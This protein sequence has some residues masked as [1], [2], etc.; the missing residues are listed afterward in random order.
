M[1]QIF[2][3]LCAAATFLAAVAADAASLRRDVVTA[4][5]DLTLG[6]LFADLP[7]ERALI[8]VA[9]AP[10]AGRTVTLDGDW[11]ARVARAYDVDWT[12]GP[13]D[14]VVAIRR[15][16]PQELAAMTGA[17]RDELSRFIEAEA[18]PMAG[19]TPPQPAMERPAEPDATSAAEP[20]V[21]MVE[22]PVPR[23][24]LRRGQVIEGADLDWLAVADSRRLT[25]AAMAPE[26]L[27]GMSARRALPA[28]RPVALGDLRPPVAV[29]RGD[30]V[31][32]VM[33]SGPMVLTARGR[34]IEEGAVGDV[35]RVMNTDSN[36][37][38]HAVVTGPNGVEVG[39]GAFVAGLN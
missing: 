33:R 7:A 17:V 31:A 38:V 30:A 5:D 11:L 36:R 6:D 10:A 29:L 32:M 12:P 13:T 9:R 34:A 22:V 24:R 8:A 25:A 20:A 26:E 18:V 39:L 14:A 3:M 15:A 2:M 28:G 4:G 19:A 1:R 16:S 21:A 23:Q 37:T 35:I 27:V